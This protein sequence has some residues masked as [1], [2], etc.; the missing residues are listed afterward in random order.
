ML[1]PRIFHHI[2]VG[3][4]MPERLGPYVDSWQTVHP[5]WEHRLWTGFD[6]LEN[7]DLYDRAEEIT[8]HVGQLRSD[9]ARYELLHRH[10][11]V[12]VDCDMEALRPL[13]GLL[14][15]RC[16]AGWERQDRWVNN[17]V[18]GCEPGHPLMRE[19]IDAAPE[20]IRRNAGARPNRM[21]GPHL[22]TPLARDR[23]D[24]TVLPEAT[25]YPYC[26][27]EL[28]RQGEE[29][30]DSLAVHHWDNTRKRKGLVDA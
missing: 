2:W 30:P 29:F 21:T 27:D 5:E 13:D 4:A 22:L 18:L 1:I 17:A 20:S 9:L 28:D 12:Y 7:Q 24:V 26:W 8:P 19:L 3:P 16:F 15:L 10:G 25:F 6:D 23:A 11:G 14:D